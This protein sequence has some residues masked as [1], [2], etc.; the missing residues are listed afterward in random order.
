[1]SVPSEAVKD[2]YFDFKLAPRACSVAPEFGVPLLSGMVH[3]P[4]CRRPC[5]CTEESREDGVG[6][7]ARIFLKSGSRGIWATST[8]I[9]DVS[10]GPL[11]VQFAGL[12]A[13]LISLLSPLLRLVVCWFAEFADSLNYRI[14]INWMFFLHFGPQCWRGSV[15]G[16]TGS[17]NAT[18]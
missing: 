14:G 10:I 5:W 4:L 2:P 11:V 15:V 12:L 8:K 16:G 6:N 17:V 3:S 7:G 13:P 9:P 1:M 18:K